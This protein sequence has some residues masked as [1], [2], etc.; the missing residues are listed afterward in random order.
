MPVDE[1]YAKVCFAVQVFAFAMLSVQS[2]T[3]ALPLYEVPVILPL[4][5]SELRLLPRFTP[6]IA[7]VPQV[8]PPTAEIVV[9]KLFAEQ[10]LA[11]AYSP[12]TPVA[13]N[14]PSALVTVSTVRFVVEASPEEIIVVD[15]YGNCDAATV[16]E[17]KKTPLVH[18]EVD[19][20]SVVVEK[21][22]KRVTV[23]SG[24]ALVIVSG[25]VPLHVVPPEHD[26]EITP[27]F[28]IVRAEPPTS[29]PGLAESETPV[30]A[31]TEVVATLV[32]LFKSF[33]YATWPFVQGDVVESPLNVSVPEVVIVPPDIG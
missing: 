24:P 16:E 2:E 3:A 26:P 31:L 14:S 5:E 4:T 15:A 1:A 13:P 27:V 32:T 23:N 28:V 11:P 22:F 21:L 33:T 10:A 20:A 9:T 6:D 19:V 30:P 7:A 8:V 12:S 25:F 18:I 17:E 29:A